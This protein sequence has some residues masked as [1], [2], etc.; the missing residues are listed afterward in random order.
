M[1]KNNSRQSGAVLIMLLFVFSL[2]LTALYMQQISPVQIRLER[3]QTT[4]QALMEAKTSLMGRAILDEN[5]PGSLPCPDAN[6]DGSADLFYGNRCPS[7]IGRFPWRTLSI[8]AL[9]DADGETLWYALSANYRDHSA[10]MPLNTHSPGLLSVDAQSDVVAIVF[11]A[12]APLAH[13]SGRPSTNLT[14]YLEG[15]NADADNLF[16]AAKSASHN[17]RLISITRSELMQKI[18]RRALAEA[19]SALQY[20]FANPAHTYFPYAAL[21]SNQCE[22]ELLLSGYIPTLNT[23]CPSAMPVMAAWFNDNAW[24]DLMRYEVAAACVKSFPKCSGS[25]FIA[26]AGIENVRVRL[27]MF[28]S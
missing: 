13:Q 14:D 23:S 17:D 7:Y 22:S 10:V 18:E 2:L 8:P 16:S 1:H 6:N 5:R 24:A 26:D 21:L 27:T 4:Q 25:G 20:Y 15:K 3:S 28:G 11:S 19:A 9:Q 12:G